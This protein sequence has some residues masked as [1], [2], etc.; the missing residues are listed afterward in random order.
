[1]HYAADVVVLGAGFGGSLLAL[2]LARQGR[3]VVLAERGRHPRFAI[4][5]SSTP[6]ADSLL[7]KLAQQYDLPQLLPLCRYGSW[8]RAYPDLPRGLKRGFSYFQHQPGAPFRTDAAHSHELLVE[9]SPTDEDSDTHW[10]RSAWDEFCVQQ[11][12]SAGVEYFDQTHVARIEHAGGGPADA[13]WRVDMRRGDRDLQCAARLLFDATGGGL[14][15]QR[16]GVADATDRLYTHSRAVF[17]HFADL[18]RWEPLA[19]A[20]GAAAGEYPFPADDAALHHLLREGWMW[21][22]RFDHDVVSAGFSL[23]LHR[24]PADERLSPAEEFAAV[25]ARY[26][27]LA[28]QFHGARV[29]AP[30]GGVVRSGRLQRRWACAGGPDW[31]LL[32]TT[33]GFIDALHSSGNAHTLSGVLRLAA[34]VQRHWDSP[35]LESQLIAYGEAV[36][37]E[38]DLIDR[39]VHGGYLALGRMDL[40]A[41]YARTYFVAAT[42]CEGRIGESLQTP[43]QFSF[44]NAADAPFVAA[45]E[46]CHAR[47]VQLGRDEART[48]STGAA[49]LQEVAERLGPW[50]REGFTRDGDRRLF[51]SRPRTGCLLP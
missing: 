30:E 4:G 46:A 42:Y 51:A 41:A 24:A 23:D 11:A 36:L 10:L 8:Q 39:I 14:L 19:Q 34:L 15:P 29:V 48:P 21:Q 16:L 40:F 45:V 28:A 7:A 17:A 47:L 20:A 13:N 5:E 22:L 1:M 3:R 32:P 26:P 43:E 50:D 18:A 33:A 25:A 27:T 35:E 37:R 49:F 12:C 31:A 38:V 2:A 44:L 9:A 6:L